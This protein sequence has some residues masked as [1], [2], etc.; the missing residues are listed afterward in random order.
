MTNAPPRAPS[1]IASWAG[2]IVR[3]LDA[4][5]LDGRRL[6][7]QAGI[8]PAGLQEAGAR[9]ARPAL[10]HLWRLAVEATG[11]PAFGLT[12]IRFATPTT[13]HALGYA[14]LASATLREA[15]QRVIRYRRLIGDI[16]APRFEERDE[17]SRFIID[18]SAAPG[19][20]PF[21][22]VDA[23]AA[24]I[25][26]QARLLR[27][28]RDFSPAA[29]HLQ[30]PAPASSA[31]YQRF[32]RAPVSFAQPL[33]CLEFRR[34][35][36]E[37]PLPAANAELARQNDE[38]IARYLARLDETAGVSSRVRQVLLDSLPN[39]AP[40]KQAVAR[41]LAMSPRNL[42]RHLTAEGASFK[43]LL[44]ETRTSLAR[45]YVIAGRLPVTE[46]AFVLGFAD[47]SAFSRAFKRWTGMSPRR[48]AAERG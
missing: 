48:Y 30:R 28:E 12:A 27:G 23:F 1:S 29:V 22:A 19:A 43:A 31:P 5:G 38:A 11:D 20:V 25:V 40:T 6:A 16:V 7:R 46:I 44:N 4:Q 26:R 45:D 39:G 14:M 35:D 24:G 9:V 42:Q 36:L 13:F 41:R 3:A 18:V 34:G 17:H 47:V 2:T 33:N 8:D 15:L 10:T 21:E 32:F 37:S